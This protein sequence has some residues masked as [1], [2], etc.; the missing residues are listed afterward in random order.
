[1]HIVEVITKNDRKEFINLPKRLYKDDPFWVCQLDSAVESVF[2]PAK[3]RTFQHGE[4][5][6]WIVKNDNGITIGR[7]AAFIDRVRSAANSQPTG[8]IGFFEITENKDAAFAL[9]DTA[10]GWLTERGME[11]MDGPIN[12]GENDNNWGLLVEGFMQQGFGMPYHK[13]YYRSFFEEYGFKNYFEQ[14]SYHR[15][16]RGDDNKIVQFP[17]RMMKI[18]EWLSKRPGYS[19]RHFEFRNKEKF[20]RD[21]VEI[22]N[23]TWSLFK[24][25]FTPLDP[26]F[27]DDSIK[28]AKP[29]I[30]EELI[31]FAYFNDKPI[32][33]FILLPD[34]NQILKYFNGRM[35][36]WNIFRFIYFR[37][38]HKMTRMRAI[39]G[40]VNPAYQNS[41]VESAIFLQLYKTFKQKPWFKELELSWVG[42]YNPKMIAIYEA[43]GGKKAKTHITYRYFIKSD[44]PFIRY[45]DEMAD[46]QVYAQDNSQPKQ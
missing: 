42:D 24:E 7:I 35:N 19:F 37:T 2:D 30:D 17:E 5:I 33:F 43:L 6:R 26:V 11:A 25:D 39:V 31:W 3:N 23:S 15:D 28:K 12:F 14:Y 46:S 21:I 9:F 27:L 18:A 34:L 36:I 45:K 4:A 44:L 40:G 13:K 38:T 1:M 29:V 41:G 20:I 10:R 8:G 32:S 22:Y 16:V